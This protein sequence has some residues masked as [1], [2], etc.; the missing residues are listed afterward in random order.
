[1][2]DYYLDTR[3]QEKMLQDKRIDRK[4]ISAHLAE[5]PDVS[6][7]I[8]EFDEEGNPTNIPEREL[9]TLPIKPGEPEPVVE[10]EFEAAD[11]LSEAWGAGPQ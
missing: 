9:K 2:K 4:Q 3:L 8:V 11:P 6:D 1:M 10:D 7:K 5:L